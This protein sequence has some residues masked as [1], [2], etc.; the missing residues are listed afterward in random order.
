MAKKKKLKKTIKSFERI[1]VNLQNH[2]QADNETI[3]FLEAE[4]AKKNE[5]TRLLV[6]RINNCLQEVK[7]LYDREWVTKKDTISTDL[8]DLIKITR[9]YE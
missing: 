4:L 7:E 8:E 5:N 6:G 1:V 9:I 3:K 2:K